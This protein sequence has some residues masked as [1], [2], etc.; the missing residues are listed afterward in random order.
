L[1][2][3]NRDIIYK[4]LKTDGIDNVYATTNIPAKSTFNISG[5]YIDDNLYNRIN[6]HLDKSYNTKSLAITG[7]FAIFDIL[8]DTFTYQLFNNN[9]CTI[10]KVT[11]SNRIILFENK[12]DALKKLLK[13]IKLVKNTVEFYSTNT[14]GFITDIN[15]CIKNLLG[16]EFNPLPTSSKMLELVETKFSN[17]DDLYGYLQYQNLLIYKYLESLDNKSNNFKFIN[18][19]ITEFIQKSKKE[20]EKKFDKIQK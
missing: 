14:K 19:I 8:R 17:V 6:L 13:L 15:K 1:H 9:Y 4:T 11:Q 2:K 7:E 16:T 18:E 5:F 3:K 20:K 10:N 12:E